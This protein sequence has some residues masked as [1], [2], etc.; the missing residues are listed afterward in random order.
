WSLSKA[1]CDV[2]TSSDVLLCTA[3]ILNLCAISIDRYLTITR[4][5]EYAAK[6]TPSRMILM[7]MSVWVTSALISIPPLF[8]WRADPPPGHCELSQDVAYQFYATVGAFYLPLFVMVT[9]Y[10]KIYIVS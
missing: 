1:M 5:F 10:Y 3:S 7:I 6:R 4:P 9:V 8:G 2:W